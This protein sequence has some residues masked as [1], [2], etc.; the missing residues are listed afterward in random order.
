MP[1]VLPILIDGDPRL[2]VR[3]M[4]VEHFDASVR[5]AVDDLVASLL[6]CRASIGFG[7]A[8]A[9]P[10]IG[11][12]RRIIA[13]HL[14]AR[15]FALINPEITWRSADRS[16]VWDACLSMPNKLVQVQ[17]HRSISL[18][19]MDEDGHT[20]TWER[21]PSE[22]AELVQHE[23]DH[24]DGVL[25]TE[26]ANGVDPVRPMSERANL[27]GPMRPAHRLDLDGIL[28]ASRSV[29]PIFLHTPQFISEP[30]AAAVG[31]TLTTKIEV[32]NPI[33]SFKGRGAD[34]FLRKVQARGDGRALVCASAGNWG[35]AMAYV[36]R[37][38][39]VP[40]E[41]F[42]A[43]NVNPLKA[44]RMRELGATLHLV[45]ND[46][47]EAKDIARRYCL[48]RSAWLVEDG[49]ERE[50]SEGAG[51]MAVEL[52]DGGVTFDAVVIPLG[53][54]AM[55]NGMARWIKAA[56]P[57]TRVIGVAA[58]GAPAMANSWRER[59]VICE[60]EVNT[61]AD[62]VAVRNPV[63]EAVADMEGIVDD[64]MLVRDATIVDA[65]RLVHCHLGL[66]LEP[67]GALGI[68]ALLAQPEWFARTSVATVLCG[69]NL[70][71]DAI[72]KYLG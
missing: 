66:V 45:G 11:I 44:Q 56:S 24:L 17:R 63:P 72:G 59:T 36:C 52:L 28:E 12:N 30:M 62:G 20:R 3:S 61:I 8:I 9:A 53:N 69:G 64:V 55:L 29:D 16:E 47:D 7:R 46:F 68:A 1:N 27:I 49:M 31:C 58:H 38:H 50:I 67:A 35:Q 40:L 15:P 19:Y 71:A 48:E 34:Y 25:M 22:L 42:A 5:S 41:I 60:Q 43:K 18:R 65:M 57:S 32:L 54:G 6:N 4:E 21:L 39:G 13:M 10:Q 70:A 33:R 2:R 23:I 26:R 37:A 51:S 14:G